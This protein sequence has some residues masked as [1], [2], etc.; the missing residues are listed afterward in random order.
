[1]TTLSGLERVLYVQTFTTFYGTT[2][3]QDNL[4]VDSEFALDQVSFSP[5]EQ[6]LSIIFNE[7]ENSQVMTFNPVCALMHQDKP[8]DTKLTCSTGFK[9]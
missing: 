1:M 7:G 3:V 5:K 8:T 2:N 4:D 6:N 9:K